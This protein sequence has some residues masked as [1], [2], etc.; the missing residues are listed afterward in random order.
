ML[1]SFVLELS[2]A[3]LENMLLEGWELAGASVRFVRDRKEK[4]LEERRKNKPKQ[5]GVTEGEVLPP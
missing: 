1:I 3:Q 5:H 2:A 4:E